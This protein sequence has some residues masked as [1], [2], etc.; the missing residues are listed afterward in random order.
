MSKENNKTISFSEAKKKQKAASDAVST[1]SMA[2][3]DEVELSDEEYERQEAEYQDFLWE[4]L[5]DG[6]MGEILVSMSAK[7]SDA[8]MEERV[9][10]RLLAKYGFN[11]RTATGFDLWLC[12]T[13]E[14]L[15]GKGQSVDI[16]DLRSAI[17]EDR[18]HY[19]FDVLQMLDAAQNMLLGFGVDVEEEE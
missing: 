16:C 13:A 3:N 9:R 18:F 4:G 15:E 11:L 10:N 5:Q 14:E 8:P 1:T 6:P 2:D 19:L 7:A 17:L 12:A